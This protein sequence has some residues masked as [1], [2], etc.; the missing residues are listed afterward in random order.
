MHNHLKFWLILTFLFVSTVGCELTEEEQNA[1]DAIIGEDQNP[2]TDFDHP[3][4]APNCHEQAYRQPAAEFS[5]KVDL[6]FVVDTSG[7]LNSE[8]QQIGDGVDA[9]LAALPADVDANIGVM[10][11]HVKTRSGKLYRK[12]SNSPLVLKSSEMDSASIR[13]QLSYRMRYT[14]GESYSDGGEAMLYSFD[15]ALNED[16]LATIK[17]EGLFRDEAALVVIF[18]TDENDI[19]ARYPDG[20]TP[21]HDPDGGEVRT[22]NNYCA[23]VTPESVLQKL[24]INMADKPFVV[25]GIIYHEGSQVPSGGENEIAYGITD[26]IDQSNGAKIDLAGGNYHQ[27]LEQIGNLAVKKLNL[28]TE[29]QL[30]TTNIN[31]DSLDVL[32][33]NSAVEFSYNE[34]NGTVML[35]DYA[36]IENSEVYI[37]YC[38]PEEDPV[39]IAPVISN[40]N[41]SNIT[42]G[43]ALV[44]W[45][46]DIDATS[47]V[48]I[49]HVASGASI[50]TN[51]S[52]GVK[53]EHAIQL[54]GLNPD[55]LYSIKAISVNQG[56]RSESDAF[57]F[58]T[59]RSLN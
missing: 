58:R 53:T 54:N 43:S 1:I 8:R 3:P 36:G 34:V 21:V 31:L 18:V 59:G 7:S 47:Q 48:E 29:F 32:V 26:I 33:D 27:G 30:A 14:A 45:N 12:D 35:T 46:T 17:S 28:K 10:L 2:G 39:I 44:T 37:S 20:V 11:A 38:E 24:R 6:L 16:N 55:T 42:G 19:C 41:V 9:F 51:A 4:L 23:D 5:K 40:L 56:A 15:Q 49:T 57:V 50:L 52:S 25:S 22:F 13:S